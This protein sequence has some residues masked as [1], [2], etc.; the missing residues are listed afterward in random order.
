MREV[1]KAEFQEMFFRYGSEEDGWGADYWNRFFAPGDSRPMKYKVRAPESPRHTR[2]IIVSDY[3]CSEYRM[4]F[5][6]IDDEE[7]L[8]GR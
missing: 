1:T 2:M 6:T 7:R 5:T 4:F 3:S 8:F